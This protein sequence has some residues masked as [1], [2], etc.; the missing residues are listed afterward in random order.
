MQI[1]IIQGWHS[2]C[3]KTKWFEKDFCFSFCRS[4][5][6][7]FQ[8]ITIFHERRIFK[9]NCRPSPNFEYGR[10]R[11]SQFIGK[12]SL[13]QPLLD[14]II[15]YLQGFQTL[16]LFRFGCRKTSYSAGPVKAIIVCCVREDYANQPQRANK[17][18][19]NPSSSSLSPSHSSLT[20]SQM[21][22][23]LI[24][25]LLFFCPLH[26]FTLLP[27]RGCVEVGGVLL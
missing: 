7:L 17:P 2:L 11:D 25:A 1:L 4:T 27:E 15:Q 12:L 19:R 6:F 22:H 13:L 20:N 24:Y 21:A 16:P 23:R 5:K 8:I 9:E 10:E 3:F 18:P 14:S 26:N